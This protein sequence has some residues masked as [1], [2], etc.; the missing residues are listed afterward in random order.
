MNPEQVE[1]LKNTIAKG[2]TED[3]LKL[4]LNIAERTGLDP[5]TGQIHF[6][7]RSS[8]QPDG[9]WQERGTIQVGIDGLRVI[10]ERTGEYDGQDPPEFLHE[11]GKVIAATV[12]VYR[13]GFSRPIAATAYWEE[14]V[15][16]KRDGSPVRM[17]DKMPHSQL[18]KCAE[19][20]ALRKAFPHDL[21]GL[22]ARE[23]MGQ[24]ENEALPAPAKALPPHPAG[25][26]PATGAPKI[27]PQE[28]ATF[29]S[30]TIGQELVKIRK[31]TAL[32]N[33]R[34]ADLPK[35]ERAEA[36]AEWVGLKFGRSQGN[37]TPEE[38]AIVIEALEFEIAET[39]ANEEPI[40]H[41]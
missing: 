21:S 40:D 9:S 3:E 31:L 39:E 15:Q 6:I 23:E 8:Q 14:Y 35:K 20:L 25:G 22:Y 29:T 5:F 19:A 24:A 17:W 27:T 1:T 34:W 32:V 26:E 12:R 10:A 7:K 33:K 2:A 4:F 16:Q 36:Y 37:M 41:E 30:E 28:E 11:A 38:R 18:A 13:K